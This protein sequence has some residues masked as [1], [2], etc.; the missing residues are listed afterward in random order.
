MNERTDE[1][2]GLSS[3]RIVSVRT[4]HFRFRS[5]RSFA[6]SLEEEEKVEKAQVIIGEGKEEK[7]PGLA[8]TGYCAPNSN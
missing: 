8:W 5:R 7:R 1:W 6:R 4:V 3:L 2:A